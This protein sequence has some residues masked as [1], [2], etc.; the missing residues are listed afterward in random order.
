MV[1]DHQPGQATFRSSLPEDVDWK[2]LPAF[3]PSARL[4]VLRSSRRPD[5]LSLLENRLKPD[6][7]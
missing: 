1:G 6:R 7:T 5:L 4:A 2:P 3:P